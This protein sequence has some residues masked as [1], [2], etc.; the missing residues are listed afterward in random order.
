MNTRAI[1]SLVWQKWPLVALGASVAMLLTAH[2]FERIGHMPPC[3]LCLHQREAYW[4]AISIS[5]LALVASRF[6]A[7]ALGARAF[8]LLLAFA[9]AAGASVAGFHVGVEQHWW[10]GLA[11]CASGGNVEAAQD[12]LGALS[13]P[14]DAPACDAIAWSFLG[15]SMAGWNLL[16][17]LALATMSL[18]AFGRPTQ[19]K[20]TGH[21]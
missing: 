15:L 3:A 5:A 21:D 4:T 1:W 16:I 10:P 17:S 8:N 2:G 20:D 6:G 19:A 9:F 13:K 18:L 14:M 12:I 11:T 7:D